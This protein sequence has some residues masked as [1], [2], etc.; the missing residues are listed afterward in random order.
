MR[1]ENKEL[2]KLRD[3]LQGVKKTNTNMNKTNSSGM[4]G[5]EGRDD[6]YWRRKLDGA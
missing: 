2:K 5:S 6:K 1:K 4:M 3:D